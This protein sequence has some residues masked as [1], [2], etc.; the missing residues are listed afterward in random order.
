MDGPKTSTMELAPLYTAPRD[1]FFS[2]EFP[3]HIKSLDRVKEALG[4]PLD[5]RYRIK[6]P[7]A[8]PI[9]GDTLSTANML[10]KATK[11]YK[12]K[13]KPGAQRSLPPYREPTEDDVLY[14]EDEAPE[15]TFEMIGMVPKT[16]RFSG[17]ADY[18]HIVDPRDELA[19]IK[20]DLID[21]NYEELISI[22]VD[23]LNPVE[24]YSTTQLVPPPYISKA[25][26]PMPY[27]YKARNGTESELGIDDLELDEQLYTRK[28]GGRR[29]YKKKKADA[30]S[31]AVSTNI[32][33]DDLE[34]GEEEE[35]DEEEDEEEGED[36]D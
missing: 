32:E 21:I 33:S 12:V 18:Q 13:R 35:R 19:K 17:L 1:K 2:V 27:K 31:S 23:N 15:V 7:F 14:D 28:K 4:A 22:K 20:R 6:D 8:I 16:T 30:S 11:R 9:Q 3:G 26:V 5:L 29:R 36:D 24:D 10:L 34:E 25:N